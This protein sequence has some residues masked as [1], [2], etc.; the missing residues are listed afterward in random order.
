MRGSEVNITFNKRE[1]AF[2]ARIR[3]RMRHAE[4][5]KNSRE[6]FIFSCRTSARLSR[7]VTRV[8]ADAAPLESLLR[9]N[10]LFCRIKCLVRSVCFEAVA[11][12]RCLLGGLLAR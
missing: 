10:P 1:I 12:G 7:Y 11:L 6:S 9:S 3:S 2:L 5:E 4:G 8:S